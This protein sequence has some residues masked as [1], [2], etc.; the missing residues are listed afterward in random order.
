MGLFCNAKLKNEVNTMAM[1]RREKKK[2]IKMA[3]NMR[4]LHYIMIIRAM[5]VR[6]GSGSTYLYLLYAAAFNCYHSTMIS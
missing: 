2:K 6:S 4:T 1:S 3:V 5:I